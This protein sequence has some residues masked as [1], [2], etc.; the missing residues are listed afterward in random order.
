MHFYASIPKIAFKSIEYQ[1]LLRSPYKLKRQQQ[2]VKSEKED[3]L[4]I[5]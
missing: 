1:H 2:N 4:A 5:N 3:Y